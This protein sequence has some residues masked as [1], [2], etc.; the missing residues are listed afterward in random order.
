M[1]LKNFTFWIEQYLFDIPASLF[2]EL[3][4]W[5]VAFVT[6]LL[7]FNEFPTIVLDRWP[8]F[9]INPDNTISIWSIKMHVAYT[10]WN[11]LSFRLIVLAPAIGTILLFI[12]SPY[13]LWVYYLARISR[14]WLSVN[15]VNQLK[16]GLKALK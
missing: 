1:K 9:N 15:D 5:I 10:G 2:H 11:D 4:H 12:F 7:G 6:Y 13:W 3:C 14:F 8:S 16:Q